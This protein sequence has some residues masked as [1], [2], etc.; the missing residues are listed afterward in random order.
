MQMLLQT[1]LVST[2]KLMH[3]KYLLYDS[4]CIMPIQPIH[5]EKIRKWRNE[6]K[7]VL[8]QSHCITPEQQIKYYNENIWPDMTSDQPKNILLS[9]LEKN[10]PIGYGG[11]T[12]IAWDHL[13]AEI[14]FLLDPKHTT[15]QNV[16]KNYFSNF[17][18][19]IKVLAFENLKLVKVFTETFST[20]EHHIK[21]LEHNGFIR[22]G[23][24][25]KHVIINGKCIDSII[26]GYVNPIC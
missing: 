25:R 21:I 10:I 22:E 2:Y 9:I 16:Y 26:H 4:I 24:L 8:R 14:S 6:Q 12:H 19:L 17:L 20:R 23:V 1:N 7:D 11:L 15:N 3:R 13:R 18:Y 5:I